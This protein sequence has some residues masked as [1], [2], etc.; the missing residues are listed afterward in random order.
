MQIIDDTKGQTLVAATQ[1]ELQQ[2]GGTKVEQAFVLGKVLAEK[3]KKKKIRE[4]VFDRGA[5]AYHGRVKA[6][7]SGAREG[8][9]KF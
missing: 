3:A 4:V 5:F 8:G 2:A 7:A 6:L 1:K 9:L